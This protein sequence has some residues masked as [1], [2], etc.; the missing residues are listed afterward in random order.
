MELLVLLVLDLAGGGG[1][2]TPETA[3][4]GSPDNNASNASENKGALMLAALGR[5][6]VRRRRWVLAGTLAAAVVAGALG[7]GMFERLSGGGFS[8]PDAES[9]RAREELER[10]FGAGDPNLVLLVTATHGS[11]D[12][13]AVAAA[14]AALTEEL[15][16][17]PSVQQTSSY[18]TAGAAP[19]LRSDDWRQ[20]LVLARIAGD[21]DQVDGAVEELAPRYTRDTNLVTVAVGGPAAVFR[22][23]SA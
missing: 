1:A 22:Q 19:P 18:W 14:G 4:T 9:S 3:A 6:A 17:E 11:V 23:I 20:A 5:F 8:D 10:V 12:D 21:E 16:S 15:V 13:P 2:T 7:G